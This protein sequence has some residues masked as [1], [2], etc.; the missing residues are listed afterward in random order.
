MK[1]MRIVLFAIVASSALA[2]AAGENL[3]V[4]PD[5]SQF[6]EVG[7]IRGWKRHLKKRLVTT[8]DVQSNGDGA[9]RVSAKGEH[10]AILQQTGIGLVPGGRYRLS[11]ELRTE[12]DKGGRPQFFIHDGNWKWGEEQNGPKAPDSTNGQWLPLEKTVVAQDGAGGIGHV[13]SI[14]CL[15]SNG[16][17]EVCFEIRN[18]RLEAVDA[19]TAAKSRPKEC[20]ALKARIVPVDPLLTAVDPDNASMTFFWPGVPVCGRTNCCVTAHIDDKPYSN[21][22]LDARGYATVAFGRIEQGRHRLRVVIRDSGG[23]WLAADEYSI[24]A[25]HPIP[26]KSIGRKLNNFVRELINC[27]LKNGEV[28][29]TCARDGWVWIYFGKVSDGADA[30]SLRGFLDGASSPVVLRRDGELYLE[31]QRWLAAG[32]HR[33]CVVGAKPGRT[34]KIHAVKTIWGS[35]PKNLSSAPCDFSQVFSYT[36]PFARRFSLISTLNTIGKADRYLDGRDNAG[37]EFFRERGIALRGTDKLSPTHKT[38]NDLD[39]LTA[40]LKSGNWR[41]GHT[42]VVDENFPDPETAQGVNF[43]EAIWRLFREDNAHRVNVFYCG[44]TATGGYFKNP[45]VNVSEIAAVVNTGMG[46]GLLCP[47]CY[48]PVGKDRASLDQYIDGYANFVQSAER[49]VPAAKGATLIYGS[50]YIDLFDYSPYICP[51]SDIKAQYSELIRAVATDPRFEGCAGIGFGGGACCEEE[52]RRWGTK[53]TRHY[54]LEGATD[55]LAARYG[56]KWTPG[57]VKNADFQDGEANWTFR[58]AAGGSIVL[59]SIKKYGKQ[60]Q[61]RIGVSD[62]YGDTVATFKTSPNGAN[63]VRQE[64]FGLEPGRYYALHFAVA[65][66]GTL[67]AC[68]GVPPVVPRFFSARL[69]GAERVAELCYEHLRRGRMAPGAAKNKASLRSYR[70]VFKAKHPDATLVLADCAPDGRLNES[71]VELSLNYIIF[72][73]YYVESES[74]VAEIISAL[75]WEG[76]NL[77]RR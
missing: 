34:L 61:A 63:E 5:L 46:T 73:P 24:E 22:S 71:G 52:F 29:F 47:E 25:R 19:K 55:D 13:L 8:I 21:A 44:D 20:R 77:I 53:V 9:F 68:E 18:L 65:D 50:G 64:I 48:A 51:E 37:A 76:E 74:E 31:T 4:N 28:E 43:S 12:G 45:E 17:K 49:M 3:I 32:K 11:Y 10:Y 14:H 54:A 41:I 70:F 67:K 2:L 58:P 39:E 66:K 1:T 40:F 6:D 33:L 26:E 27:P 42:V 59:E 56:Y 69:E 38:R 16:P 62:G 72:R 60:Y 57:F 75:G 23:K 7:T 30:D 15:Q 36:L 35:A